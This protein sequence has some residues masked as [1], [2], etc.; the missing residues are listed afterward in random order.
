MPDTSKSKLITQL[1]S[2]IEYLRQKL[3]ERDKE[4]AEQKKR[5]DA[6]ILE[7]IQQLELL[8][9]HRQ[10]RAQREIVKRYAEEKEDASE[11]S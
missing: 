9:K 3:D 7:L 1:Q 8:L 11:G 2:E 6:I 5:S 10:R 4:S